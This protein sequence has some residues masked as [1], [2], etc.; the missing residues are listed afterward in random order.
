MHILAT[1][2]LPQKCQNLKMEIE[3]VLPANS[4]NHLDEKCGDGGVTSRLGV[5]V[6]YTGSKIRILTVI[7]V[8]GIG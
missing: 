8:Q 5:L 4:Q 2:R 7:F 3:N 1:K 6:I